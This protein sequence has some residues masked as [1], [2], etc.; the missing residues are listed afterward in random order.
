MKPVQFM[1]FYLMWII[2]SAASRLVKSTASPLICLSISVVVTCTIFAFCD[3]EGNS[4]NI[5]V[6]GKAAN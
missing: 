5:I 4:G 6:Y 3:C 1:P 2:S